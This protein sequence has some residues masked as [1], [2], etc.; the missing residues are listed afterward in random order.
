MGSFDPDVNLGE[1]GMD[2]IMGV[3]IKNTLEREYDVVLSMNEIRHL[4]IK[5]LKAFMDAGGSSQV[6]TNGKTDDLIGVQK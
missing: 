3:E 6:E 2:S 4:S 1:L 5:Q